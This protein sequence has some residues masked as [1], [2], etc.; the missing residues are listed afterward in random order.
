MRTSTDNIMYS[1]LIDEA[2]E[3]PAVAREIAGPLS[4]NRNAS[5]LRAE[6]REEACR[7][8]ARLAASAGAP[9]GIA[10]AERA[11]GMA[12]A[13]RRPAFLEGMAAL[14]ERTT[15]AYVDGRLPRVADADD[16]LADA[17][18]R[19]VRSIA[20]GARPE[21][22]GA[23]AMGIAK[24]AVAD[25]WRTA[26]RRP[27]TTSMTDEEG[28]VMDL[29]D[30]GGARDLECFLEVEELHD[31]ITELKDVGATDLE[32]ERLMA[33][34]L[35]DGDARRA[36]ELLKNPCS[37]GALNQSI[38]SLRNRLADARWRGFGAGR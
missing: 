34:V 5:A 35:A 25:W 24:L 32:I 19:L 30:H 10:D 2:L 14:E 21:R 1:L 22:G 26:G 7:G 29:A 3:T 20:G 16:V 36:V 4:G 37:S 6:I 15:R 12:V 23:Y 11:V 27:S 8:L 13:W 17:R 9:V 38:T 18:A 28:A 33:F 31:L